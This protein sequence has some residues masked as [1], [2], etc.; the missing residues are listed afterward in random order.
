MTAASSADTHALRT[1]AEVLGPTEGNG[2]SWTLPTKDEVTISSAWGS[3]ELEA[4]LLVDPLDPGGEGLRSQIGLLSRG[5]VEHD[6]GVG[7][8]LI[9]SFPAAAPSLLTSHTD[10]ALSWI[11]AVRVAEAVVVADEHAGSAGDSSARRRLPLLRRTRSLVLNG[12]AL[13]PFPGDAHLT[14]SCPL[15]GPAELAR[16]AKEARENW[17][18]DLLNHEELPALA[19]WDRP[20]IDRELRLLLLRPKGGPWV[21]DPPYVRWVVREGFLPRFMLVDAWRAV[22]RPLQRLALAPLLFLTLIVVACLVGLTGAVPRDLLLPG[23]PIVATV[24]YA[25][26]I[27]A[28]GLAWETVY[29]MCLRLPA[30]AAVGLLAVISFNPKWVGTPGMTWVLASTAL[31]LASWAYLFVEALAHGVPPVAAGRRSA[32]VSAL[33]FAHALAVAA[34]ALP[35]VGRAFSADLGTELDQLTKIGLSQFYLLAASAG[36]AVGVFLQ[37]LWDDHPVTYPLTHLGWKGRGRG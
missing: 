9:A 5:L 27:V 3:F 36:L 17:F 33:G 14:G 21:D 19:T 20:R 12:P 10:A 6:S 24:A 28:A 29:L 16:R 13:V 8:E 2:W 30:G 26:V 25:L 31:L 18:I 1:V 37:M 11:I 32:L 35:V 23:A 15:G 22:P 4:R 7:R 34:I